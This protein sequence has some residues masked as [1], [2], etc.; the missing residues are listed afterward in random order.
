M[1]AVIYDLTRINKLK[2]LHFTLEYVIFALN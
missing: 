1:M 2:R